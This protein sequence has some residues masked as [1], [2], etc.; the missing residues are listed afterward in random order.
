M[1]RSRPPFATGLAA[2]GLAAAVIVYS[3]SAAAGETSTPIEIFGRLPAVEDMILSPS[4]SEKNHSA[5]FGSATPS[6]VQ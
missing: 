2:A 4:I 1:K 5:P 6:C 3:H